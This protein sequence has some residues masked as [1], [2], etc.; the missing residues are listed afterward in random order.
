[1]EW[2]LIGRG[3]FAAASCSSCLELGFVRAAGGAVGGLGQR[4]AGGELAE[5]VG[6]LGVAVVGGVLVA[7]CGCRGGVAE[8]V[9][10]FGEGGSGVGGEDGAGVAQVV[11]AQ[12]G[13]PA[14]RA[15]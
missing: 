6:D 9:H 11:P 15:R 14:A 13:R 4:I 8:A 10:E 3:A 12:V 2:A 5:G 1:M 7:E